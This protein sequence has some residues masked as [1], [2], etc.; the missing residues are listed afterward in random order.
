MT[1]YESNRSETWMTPIKTYLTDGVLHTNPTEAQR[2]NKSSSRYTLLDGHLF[3]FG[4]SRPVLT[5][6]DHEESKRIM[7]ELHEGYAIVTSKDKP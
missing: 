5:Y 7:I 2:I 6:I 4:F 3:R 1:T